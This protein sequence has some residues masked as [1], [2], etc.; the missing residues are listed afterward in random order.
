[1]PIAVYFYIYFLT[2]DTTSYV[3]GAIA[4]ALIIYSSFALARRQVQIDAIGS[5]DQKTTIPSSGDANSLETIKPEGPNEPENSEELVSSEEKV[6][7]SE[8]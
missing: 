1:M 5:K 2:T 6:D 3:L 4:V 7:S 8:N